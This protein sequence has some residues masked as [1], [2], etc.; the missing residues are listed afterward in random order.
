MAAIEDKFNQNDYLLYI[1]I[2]YTQT[3]SHAQCFYTTYR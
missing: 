3:H 2:Y 1:V